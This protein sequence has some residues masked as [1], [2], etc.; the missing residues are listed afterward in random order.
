ML[1]LLYGKRVV[2]ICIYVCMLIKRVQKSVTDQLEKKKKIKIKRA[3]R[4]DGEKKVSL[5]RVIYNR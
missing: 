4:E 5:N 2:K 1:P 3:S